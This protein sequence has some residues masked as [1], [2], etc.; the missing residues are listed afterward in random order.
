[1]IDEDAKEPLLGQRLVDFFQLDRMPRV[2]AEHYYDVVAQMVIN[3]TA[4]WAAF[5]VG[6]NRTFQEITRARGRYTHGNQLFAFDWWQGLPEDWR[7]DF[8]LGKFRIPR[9]DVVRWYSH[10]PSVVF[11]DG[12]FADTLTP[13]MIDHMG[14]L[15]LVHIDCDLY[16]STRLVLERLPLARG[17]IVMFDEFYAPA[18]EWNWYDHEAKAF[19]EVCVE[20][21]LT[22]W[23]LCRRDVASA[24]FSEQA[25]FLLT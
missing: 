8:P 1:M 9:E 11:V 13:S 21:S 25:S 16:S 5:G 4:N 15:A 10:D 18:G 24:T 6:F 19:Y 17:T 3:R 23:P 22:V 20:R 7:P 14:E 2:R 12:V